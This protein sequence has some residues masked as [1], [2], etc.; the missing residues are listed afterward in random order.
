MTVC[1][2]SESVENY[3]KLS[4]TVANAKVKKNKKQKL[5]NY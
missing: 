3:R 5:L 2:R 1:E 4:K